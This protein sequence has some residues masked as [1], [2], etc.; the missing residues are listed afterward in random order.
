MLLGI[1]IIAIGIHYGLGWVVFWGLLVAL[2][3]NAK[4]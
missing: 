2:S 1:I 4:V 3:G